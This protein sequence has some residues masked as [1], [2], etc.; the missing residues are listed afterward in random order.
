[1]A[2]C[3][4]ILATQSKVVCSIGE[5]GI[6]GNQRLPHLTAGTYEGSTRCRELIAGRP[7]FVGIV[8]ASSYGVG[9]VVLGEI[10]EGIPTVFQ[11]EWLEDIRK[12]I[13]SFVN[14]TGCITNSDLEMVGLLL[15][16][17]VIKGLCGILVEKQVALFSNNMPTVAWVSCL[18][19]QKSLVAEYFVQ[20]HALQ[21]N[22]NKTF[23]LTTLHIEGKQNA[24]TDIPSRSFGSNPA[25][26]CISDSNFL[27]FFN[28]I[29]PISAQKS[30]T[31]FYPSYKVIIHMISML[32]MQ[33]SELNKWCRL[34]RG[35]T[36]GTL[37]LLRQTFG[38]GPISSGYPVP[39]EGAV[40]HRICA[41]SPI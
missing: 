17:L 41:P 6:H 21:L 22:T 4:C 39:A 27:T 5:T 7:D 24:I 10:L 38:S 12:E 3:N 32:R 15:L 34:P 30:W 29:F 8:N 33:H 26:H 1:M 23:P 19:S 16:W 40:S 36:L 2:L 14:P 20:A 18:V 11:W 37:A 28:S 9:R 13:R 25:W 35:I 31:V